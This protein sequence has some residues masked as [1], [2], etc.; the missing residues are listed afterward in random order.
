MSASCLSSLASIRTPS[1]ERL[2]GI[3]TL[4]LTSTSRSVCRR[5]C[6]MAMLDR[7]CRRRQVAIP[8]SKGPSALTDAYDGASPE[9][10]DPPFAERT[11]AMSACVKPSETLAIPYRALHRRTGSPL[12]VCGAGP[13]MYGIPVSQH[14][15]PPLQQDDSCHMRPRVP[16]RHGSNRRLRSL[17]SDQS[18]RP[19]RMPRSC[20]LVPNQPS[21]VGFLAREVGSL[22]SR[23]SVQPPCVTVFARQPLARGMPKRMLVVGQAPGSGLNTLHGALSWRSCRPEP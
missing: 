20:R 8:E 2:V 15:P 10:A 3:D 23:S 14:G 5:A 1:I 6:R 22:V 13:L 7:P 12:D 11:S 18:S 17:A 19:R 4:A 16:A 9:V 21:E